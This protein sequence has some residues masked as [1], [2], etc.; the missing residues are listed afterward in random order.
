MKKDKII[1]CQDC[2]SEFAWTVGEQEFYEEKGLEEPVRCPVCRATFRAA[3]RDK[4]KG[5]VRESG[6]KG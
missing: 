2:Q 4:F 5:K 3:Q 1:I 6:K